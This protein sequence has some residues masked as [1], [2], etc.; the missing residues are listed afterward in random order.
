MAKHSVIF[1][2]S[3]CKPVINISST[4]ESTVITLENAIKNY[5]TEI[6]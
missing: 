5:Y 6:E 1:S 4:P 3:V 2:Y